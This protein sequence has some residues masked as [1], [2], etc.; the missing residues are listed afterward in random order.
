MGKQTLGNTG[1]GKHTLGNVVLPNWAK[2]A[3]GPGSGQL[4]QI[5][6]IVSALASSVAIL[7]FQ[8]DREQWLT[9]QSMR[10]GPPHTQA[11]TQACQSGTNGTRLK[12]AITFPIAPSPAFPTAPAQARGTPNFQPA[13][14]LALVQRTYDTMAG[15]AARYPEP[16]VPGFPSISNLIEDGVNKNPQ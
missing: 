11:P 4:N 2:E 10:H 9:K 7:K 8:L 14:I 6:E 13:P 3:P 12:Q 1:L 16:S 15:V 5:L